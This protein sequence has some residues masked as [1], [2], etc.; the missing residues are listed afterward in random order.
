MR[1]AIAVL[2]VIILAGCASSGVHVSESQVS[3]FSKGVTTY[4]EVVAVLGSPTTRTRDA[5]GNVTA[6]YV[7]TEYQTR[8]ETFIPY[9]GMLVGGTDT[10]MSNANFV[11]SPDGILQDYNFSESAFGTSTNFSQQNRVEQRNR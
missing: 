3:D 10:R 11:F 4:D 2:A 8:P 7:Y 9:A 5:S 1:K 6:E